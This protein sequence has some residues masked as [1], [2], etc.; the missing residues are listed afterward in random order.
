VLLEVP[1]GRF[2]LARPLETEVAVARRY[3]DPGHRIGLYPGPV[4]VELL[5]TEAVRRRAA[6][7][8]DEFCSEHVSYA[9]YGPGVGRADGGEA[10]TRFPCMK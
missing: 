4:N 3:R 1:R 10:V 6:L 7:S 8:I 5:G 2:D 9:A